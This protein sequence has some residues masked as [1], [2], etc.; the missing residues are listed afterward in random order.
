LDTHTFLWWRLD[1]PELSAAARAAI[2]DPEND[3][4]ISAVVAWEI[5]IKQGLGRLRFDGTVA[6]AIADEGFETLPI[7][8]Q[9]A[10]AVGDL[11]MHHR[12]PFDRLLIAQAQVT[13][14]TL[15]THDASI[16]RYEGVAVL[17]I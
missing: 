11:P 6:A 3:V 15:M 4:L 10:E 2:M 1:A 8:V 7:T 13:G 12:D 5:T 16:R 14:C 17:A 9:H